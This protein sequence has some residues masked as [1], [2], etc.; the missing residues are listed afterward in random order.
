MAD[1]TGPVKPPARRTAYDTMAWAKSQ[2]TGSVGRKAVLMALAERTGEEPVC[3][4]SQALLAAETEQSERTVRRHLAE[5]EE[6]GL[7]ASRR[8]YTLSD[9]TRLPRGR[10]RNEYRLAVDQP[11]KLA[12]WSG[13]STGQSG[14]L[15][16]RP[17]GQPGT[18]NRTPAADQ[19]DTAVSSELPV[20]PPYQKGEAG[21]VDPRYSPDVPDPEE[22]AKVRALIAESVPWR[23]TPSRR[24]LEVVK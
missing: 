3:W 19:P 4:P 11:D 7:I 13:G 2:R 8:C 24:A 12:A 18:T 22:R 5:M 15:V 1:D 21:E 14:R 23:R 20:E 17:T 16:A 10:A 9:G 6:A